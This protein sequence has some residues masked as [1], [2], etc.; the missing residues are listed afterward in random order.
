LG[1]IFIPDDFSILQSRFGYGLESLYP[2]EKQTDTNYGHDTDGN[3][4]VDVGEDYTG[5]Y[6]VNYE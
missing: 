2:V 3:T 5:G 4:V 1:V 6:Y